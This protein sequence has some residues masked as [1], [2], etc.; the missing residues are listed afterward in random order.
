[1]AVVVEQLVLVVQLGFKAVTA[2]RL[3][4]PVVR[5]RSPVVWRQHQ[6]LAVQLRS[7]VGLE[8]AQTKLVAE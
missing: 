5:L 1:L 7:K 4:A 6:V 8:S 3:Q 2:A